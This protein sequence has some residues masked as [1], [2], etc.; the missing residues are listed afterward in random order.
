MKLDLET[1]NLQEIAPVR[2]W[3]V[4]DGATINPSPDEQIRR[5]CPPANVN[6]CVVSNPAAVTVDGGRSPAQVHDRVVVARLPGDG[7][8][9]KETI[10]RKRPCA[11]R[12]K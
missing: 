3:G 10:Q 11:A 12:R 1:Q 4:P 5:I 7:I 2:E 8:Q 6:S 9:F